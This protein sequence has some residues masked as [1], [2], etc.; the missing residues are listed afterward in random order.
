M[1]TVDLFALG[2][3]VDTD[4][5]SNP[6]ADRRAASRWDTTLLRHYRRAA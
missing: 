3:A 2:G 5:D 1:R 6:G 4:E